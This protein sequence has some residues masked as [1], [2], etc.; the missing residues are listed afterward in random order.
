MT[1]VHARNLQVGD[2]LI[3]EDDEE[4]VLD[5]VRGEDFVG[6]RTRNLSLVTPLEYVF[7]EQAIVEIE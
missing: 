6:V 4:E 3:V 2:L 5:L 7:D 1:W